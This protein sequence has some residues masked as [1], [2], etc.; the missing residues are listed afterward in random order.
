LSITGY[1]V[2]FEKKSGKNCFYGYSGYNRNGLDPLF[3]HHGIG[4]TILWRLEIEEGIL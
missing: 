1:L 4:M 2:E 3:L